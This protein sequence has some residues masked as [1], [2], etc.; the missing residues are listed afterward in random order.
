MGSGVGTQM[1][2]ISMKNGAVLERR[3]AGRT[4]LAKAGERK[5]SPEGGREGRAEKRERGRTGNRQAEGR[6]AGKIIIVP[7]VEGVGETGGW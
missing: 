7:R 3:T 5:P 1:G 6:W 4:A 2:A